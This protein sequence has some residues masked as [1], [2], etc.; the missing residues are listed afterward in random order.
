MKDF[1]VFHSRLKASREKAGLFQRQLAEKMNVSVQTISAYER[2][3]LPTLENVALIADILNVSVDWLLGIEKP[4]DGPLDY[5]DVFKLIETLEDALHCT[6]GVNRK[7]MQVTDNDPY[8]DLPTEYA[9]YYE[10][11]FT[12]WETDLGDVLKTR[13][14]LLAIHTPQ[15]TKQEIYSVWRRGAIETLKKNKVDRSLPF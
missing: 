13:A 12:D 10:I 7:T 2:E 5:S 15:K 1:S 4:L 6:V 8:S 9:D 3:K 11:T 14:E